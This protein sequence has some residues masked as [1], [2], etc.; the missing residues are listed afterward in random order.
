MPVEGRIYIPIIDDEK[1]NICA[2]CIRGCP[3]EIIPEQRREEL[4]LRGRIYQD[5]KSAPSLGVGPVEMPPCQQECPIHQDIR[6]YIKLISDRKYTEALKLIRETNALPSVTG[7]ICH[8]PCEVACVRKFIEEPC[9]IKNLK[10]F[11]A[12]FDDGR[13]APPEIKKNEEKVSIIGSGPSGLAAAYDLARN[14]YQVEVIEALAEPGGML[15]WAIPPFR[16]PRDILN[17]DIKYIERMGVAI[18]TSVKFGVDVTLSGLKKK[19]SDAIIMAI[20]THQGLEIG[21][22]NERSISGYIDCLAFLR[23]YSNGEQVALG[24]KVIVVGGGNAAIDAARSGLRCDAKEVVIIYRR[25]RE[26]MPADRDEVSE[27]AAEGVKI[28]YLVAPV[29]IIEKNGQIQGLECIKTGLGE[30][31]ESGRR[32]PIPIKGS[33]FVLD[34][35]SVI[36]AIGQQ[37]DLSWNQEGLPF[38]F[39]PKNTFIVDDSGS[40]NMKGVFAIGD[41]VNGPTTVVEAMA[42]GKKVAESVKAYLSGTERR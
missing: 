35:T 37:P 34:A 38:N 26:E 16:L 39:S 8:H 21:I 10:R 17:R 23:K 18:K 42:S 2:A 12:D 9:V 28:N 36:P 20:G 24:D 41:A 15:R 27:A 22:E 19:G 13:L 33:E 4:S 31:D 40:T 7:Y 6:G 25:S 1:C 11:V 32:R 3:A 29:R 14:G 5:I 30:P